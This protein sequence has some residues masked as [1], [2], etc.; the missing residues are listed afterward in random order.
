MPPGR[1]GKS[2]VTIRVLC[3]AADPTEPAAAAG[4]RCG[5]LRGAGRSTAPRGAANGGME[6]TAV[7]RPW[8]L[9]PTWDR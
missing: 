2:L 8:W 9:L 4:G 5:T 7:R 3:I 1:G 6:T